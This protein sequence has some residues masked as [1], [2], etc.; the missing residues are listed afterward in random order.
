VDVLDGLAGAGAKTAGEAILG[1]VAQALGATVRRGGDLLTRYDDRQFAALLPEVSHAGACKVAGA[2][3]AAVAG[4]AL[5]Q[6]G[7]HAK[8][9]VSV[10]LATVR[11]RLVTS[12]NQARLLALA[13]SALRRAE[14]EGGNRVSAHDE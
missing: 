9:T 2:L 1:K 12:A 14:R 10:G 3:R 11:P 7:A 5:A 6:P 4:L 8:V 13:E